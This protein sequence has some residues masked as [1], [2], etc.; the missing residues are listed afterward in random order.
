MKLS[1]K[2]GGFLLEFLAGKPYSVINPMLYWEFIEAPVLLLLMGWVGY[3]LYAF[4][5]ESSSIEFD[6][7]ALKVY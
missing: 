7:F 5:S 1:A 6:L 4:W 2:N 3:K